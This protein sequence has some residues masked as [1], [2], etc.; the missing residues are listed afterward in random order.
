MHAINYNTIGHV[1]CITIISL[2]V[3]L[4]K[5]SR[6]PCKLSD[7]SNKYKVPGQSVWSFPMGAV[8]KKL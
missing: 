5:Y 2:T 8:H 4:S 6:L 7:I 3:V 1:S